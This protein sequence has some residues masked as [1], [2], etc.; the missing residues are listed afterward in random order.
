MKVDVI[1]QHVIFVN[2]IA[3][4]PISLFVD[5]SVNFQEIQD[6]FELGES[7]TKESKKFE[8]CYRQ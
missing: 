7:Q 1:R 3:I 4:L 2:R 5:Y 6:C 8:I